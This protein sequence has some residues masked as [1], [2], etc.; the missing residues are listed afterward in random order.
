MAHSHHAHD[1]HGTTVSSKLLIASIATAMFVAVEIVIGI[2][3]NSLALI[4]DAL[5][6]V[7]DTLALLLALFAVRVEKRPATTAKSYGWHRAG[8]LAAFINAGVLVALTVFLF[9]EAAQRLR[10]PGPVNSTAMLLTASVALLLNGAITFWLRAEGKHDLNIRGAVL[11][12]LGD[13]VSSAGIIGAALLIR[14]TGALFW[15]PA[16]TIV[17]G[18]LILWSSWGILREAIN[19]LLEGTPAG[20]N[21]EA[22][23]QAIRALDGVAGVHHLHIWALGASRPA[24]SC[25]LMVGDIPVR[26]TGNLLA[27]V[28]QMLEHDYGITHTTVQFEFADCD[29]DDPYCVPYETTAGRTS[30]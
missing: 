15:D 8:V 22:V 19:L 6:N 10:A 16:V 21:P 1:S 29:T 5:H 12:M 23:T 18:V 11:H 9:V 27:Q 7:T 20:I 14:A 30:G 28:N 17:I 3:A 13:A 26:S 4:G 2:R 24:L 25:H